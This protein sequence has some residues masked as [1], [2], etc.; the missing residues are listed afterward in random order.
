MKCLIKNRRLRWKKKL[1][2]ENFCRF[3]EIELIDEVTGKSVL[4]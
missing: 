4:V 1:I 3:K 2:E